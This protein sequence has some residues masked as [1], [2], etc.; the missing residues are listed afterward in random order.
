MP[1][2]ASGSFN[3]L[4]STA[5]LSRYCSSYF[6]IH[7]PEAN[8]PVSKVF[9]IAVLKV[10]RVPFSDWFFYAHPFQVGRML[11]W[12]LVRRLL[13]KVEWKCIVAFLFCNWFDV[14]V[15]V[16]GRL[17]VMDEAWTCWGEVLCVQVDE[18]LKV[19]GEYK[20]VLGSMVLIKNIWA[21]FL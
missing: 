3:S 7:D 10:L 11:L 2:T 19:N 5:G 21:I 16:E 17:N 13:M 12:S 4:P 9:S 8:F 15:M 1:S 14:N 20:A 6:G 18:G